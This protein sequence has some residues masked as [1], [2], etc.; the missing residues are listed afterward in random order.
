MTKDLT[1]E[2]PLEFEIELTDGSKIATLGDVE[3]YIRDGLNDDQ[4]EASHWA[5]AVE[6]F[7]SA[8]HDPTFL[9][10]TT[11]ALQTALAL[12]GLLLRM[13]SIDR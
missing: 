3:T 13:Q 8:R 5:I 12:D 9:K 6:M 11:M 7:D 1:R 10:S 2:A 4:R